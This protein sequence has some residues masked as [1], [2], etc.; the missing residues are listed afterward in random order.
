MPLTI[1]VFKQK[2]RQ[3]SFNRENSSDSLSK[4][5]QLT[6]G[7]L[8]DILIIGLVTGRRNVLKDGRFCKIKTNGTCF[9]FDQ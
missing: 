5:G 3:N 6:S 8:M 2:L 9:G 4:R 7:F 1:A